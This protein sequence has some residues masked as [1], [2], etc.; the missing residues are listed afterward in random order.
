MRHDQLPES[1]NRSVNRCL[2][3][4]IRTETEAHFSHDLLVFEW[5]QPARTRC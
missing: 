1:G 3:F 4:S 5:R 2:F